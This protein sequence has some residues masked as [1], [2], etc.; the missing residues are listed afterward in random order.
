[1]TTII[2]TVVDIFTKPYII[3]NIMHPVVP[4]KLAD[5][6]FNLITTMAKGSYIL[7]NKV[8]EWYKCNYQEKLYFKLYS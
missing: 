2:H 3:Q 1:M 6:Y 4:V 7:G 5:K 8:R